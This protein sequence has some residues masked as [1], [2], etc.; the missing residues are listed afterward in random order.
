[1]RKAMK[2]GDTILRFFERLGALITTAIF[3]AI[4]LGV[5]IGFL[6][7]KKVGAWVP[8]VVAAALVVLVAVAYA[9]GR[10]STPL[11]DD[12]Q[13][14][15]EYEKELIVNALESLQQA[16]GT[17]APWDPDALVERG[18]L[19]AA[20]GLLIGSRAEDVRLSV[21]VPADDPPTMFRMRWA[22]GHRSESVE[23]YSRLIDET[24]AGR[25]YRRGE[26]VDRP[27]VQLDP[28]F[29]E[30]PRATR[31]FASLYAQP[32]RIEARIV[33]VFSAVS[34]ARNAFSASDIAF[35]EIVAALLDVVLAIE[36]DALR[37]QNMLEQLNDEEE[38][39]IRQVLEQFQEQLT[40]ARE[41]ADDEADD[42]EE[43]APHA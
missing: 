2:V 35:I 36:H 31:G 15:S 32:L 18:I 39:R 28:D 4:G 7:D 3:L 1:M 12:G 34:T 24:L 40:A 5:A 16:I 13:T 17:E 38:R 43:P 11:G 14:T 9:V 42:E 30:N 8:I 33:A 27:D 25:A 26:I 19:G 21:L 22:A 41:D 23:N 29:R 20:R 6:H 10:H 37:F